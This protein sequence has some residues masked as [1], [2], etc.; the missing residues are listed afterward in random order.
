MEFVYFL[1]CLLKHSKKTP[2]CSTISAINYNQEKFESDL[3][4]V[5]IWDLTVS[6][7]V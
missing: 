3:K 4:T 5:I 2:K 1:E 7:L 6:S